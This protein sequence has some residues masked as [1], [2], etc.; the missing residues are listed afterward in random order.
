[1]T[2]T[3]GTSPELTG[4]AGYTYED[5]VVA[6]YLAAL[7]REE[8]AAGQAGVVTGVAVQQAPT[9]PLDDLV[10]RFDEQGTG[11]VLSV[12]VRRKVVISGADSNDRFRG[13]LRSAAA[14]LNS[15]D[16]RAGMDACG[17]VAEYAAERRLRDLN[18]LIKFARTS[19]DGTGFERHFAGTGAASKAMRKLRR[20]LSASIQ[21][22]SPTDERQ[23]YRHFVALRMDGLQGE[24]PLGTEL[25]NRLRE[26]TAGAPAAGDTLLDVLRTI[27]REGA[28]TAQSWTRESLL[29][30]LRDRVALNVAPSYAGDMARLGDFSRA[31]LAD[32]SD[33]VAGVRVDRP[34]V[35]DGIRDGMAHHRLVNLSGL[36][37]SGKS[38]ALKRAAETLAADGPLLFL[39]H[40]RIENRSWAAFAEALGLAHGDPAQVLAE[41]GS[42]GTPTLFVDGI[43]RIDPDHKGVV[44]DV[45]RA[46]DD[47]EHLDHWSVLATSRDQ[48]LEGYRTWFP[49]SFYR[50]AGIGDVTVPPF[51]DAESAQLAQ[52]LPA[53]SP[54][55]LGS[56]N[57]AEIARRPFFTAV[58][59]RS[60]AT[61]AAGPQTE[62]DLLTEWWRR[63]GYDGP[64]A[65]VIRRQRALLDIAVKGL[66]TLGRR[67]L[68]RELDDATLDQVQGLVDDGVLQCVE[69]GAWYSFAHDIFFE[70]VFYRQLVELGKDWTDE[71]I[72]AGEPPL[73]GRVVGLLAQKAF[74]VAGAWSDGYRR[75]EMMDLR[76]QWRREWL[77]APPLTSAFTGR[78]AELTGFLAEDDHRLLG[79]FLL[80][81]QAHHTTPN[82][83]VLASD[84]VA[85]EADRIRFAD[86]LGWPS[87][88][89]AWVR[90]LGWL[91]PAAP[92]LPRRFVPV[93]VQVFSVWQN[94]FARSANVHSA[95]IVALC[96]R[97]LVELEEVLYGPP[98]RTTR[99]TGWSDLDSSGTD[100]ATNLRLTIA[101]SASTYPEPMRELYERAV[102]SKD[103]RRSVYG[104]LMAFASTAAEV[105]PEA[106]AAVTKA[107][108]M[109]E[110]PGDRVERRRR[111]QDAF[112]GY[113]RRIREK[114]EDER[115]PE[116][117]R[118]ISH[119]HLPVGEDRVH[120]DDIGIKRF[121]PY[122]SP[123]SA[124]HQ[125]Y[126]A[127]FN[128]APEIGV[129]LVRDLANH[130]VAGW[131]PVRGT[132]R[133][134]D[135][136][137]CSSGLPL[138]RASLLGR[139]RTV[140][141]VHDP[142]VARA[143]GVRIPRIAALGLQANRRGAWRGRSRPR[144]G[145]GKHLL[146]S[147]GAGSCLGARDPAC[148]RD[149]SADRHLP[150]ALARRPASV[151]AGG[152]AWHRRD[153]V[154][155]A[156]KP[157]GRPRRRE[158]LPGL[159]P[160][161]P[162][163]S[164]TSRDAF[165]DRS[166]P[167][168]GRT[169]RG[170]AG[171][172]PGRSSVHHGGPTR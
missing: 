141:L 48:G 32:V 137:S 64:T 6:Y 30:Q 126:A 139:H 38:A 94:A 149:H 39:K 125:P 97:W 42:N 50:E 41:L 105:C 96:S 58:L 114:P 121:E 74:E 109:E 37:G 170:A 47:S 90:L 171:T 120:R 143:A 142:S 24:G 108:V 57:A 61:R 117:Q 159:A 65:L 2:T 79:K 163:G 1:M 123:A 71:L 34:G 99:D 144:G 146:R 157:R 129:A 55:L 102:E 60:G 15:P 16:F 11:R 161:A 86:L 111:E 53:L 10:V 132:A 67:V 85:G 36:P 18:R 4:G 119:P 27:A 98:V 12:Q 113:L 145:R 54:L 134:G 106:L 9:F 127:L 172:V 46:I 14:T 75:L 29:R 130:A 70:W 66:R 72:R 155:T 164:S 133:G 158:G 104:E 103:M 7:L 87:D 115:T 26:L 63:G 166:R 35:A 122:Y 31:A 68:A 13:I 77:T 21:A 150:A 107:E 131:R 52:A 138:G 59:A 20:E 19:P 153:G 91:I 23:F 124:L 80:W 5:T 95:A 160:V 88:I 28:G 43:D 165:R 3:Q 136:N 110:L 156:T 51:D 44:L 167:G 152:L 81:F 128:E 62:I 82:P 118:V 33:E 100:L 40:D 112:F 22:G 168:T 84:A 140:R 78:E 101:R 17:F 49:G 151:R 148:L 73:L 89:A 116:E 162:A 69:D 25:A 83:Q 45:V 135:A 93:V 169:V 56:E 8:G 76:P 154:G 92:T 147:V